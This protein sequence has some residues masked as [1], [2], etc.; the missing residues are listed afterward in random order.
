[1]LRAIGAQIEKTTNREA[2]RDLS[3]RRLRDI[4]EEKRLKDFLA[5][6]VETEK[7]KLE[8]KRKKL[9]QLKEGPK[10]TFEDKSYFEQREKREKD[11][12]ESL[13]KAFA[14]GKNSQDKIF[15]HTLPEKNKN[16]K[17]RML[18]DLDE[19]TDDDSSDDDDTPKGEKNK[20]EEKDRTSASSTASSSCS[21][22]TPSDSVD[23]NGEKREIESDHEDEHIDKKLKT[24]Q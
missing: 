22:P 10:H 12:F 20:K 1:M 3:G 15:K 14:S 18:D 24:D 5:K 8:I 9:Q 11:I 2:C 19:S 7:E 16:V 17:R 23:K 21:S 6:K 4:N 13:D